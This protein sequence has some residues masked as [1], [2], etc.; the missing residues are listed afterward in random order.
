MARILTLRAIAFAILL[1]GNLI[2]LYVSGRFQ[3]RFP[4]PKNIRD[5]SLIF[6]N[7]KLAVLELEATLA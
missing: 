5:F 1:G 3:R 2:A 4:Q 7:C 6:K